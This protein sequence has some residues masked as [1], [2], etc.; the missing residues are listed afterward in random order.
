MKYYKFLTKENT[1]KYSKFDFTKWLPDEGKPGDWIPEVEK[2]E[3]CVSGY[4]ACSAND[5]L[6]WLGW[7]EFDLYEV[8]LGD[9]IRKDTN[10]IVSNKIRFIRK[11]ETWNDKTARLFACWCVKQIWHL[12]SD[13]RSKHAVTIAEQYANGEA[14]K[15]DMD[16]AWAAA[17]AGFSTAAGFSAWAAASTGYSAWAA[18]SARAAAADAAGDAAMA[19]AWDAQGEKLIEMLGLG[20]E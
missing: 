5:L 16:A 14:S 17:L 18:A 13:E 6:E 20:N 15:K 11:I 1:G 8:E 4:H 2:L 12:L 10:K 19:A 7:L 9:G 3:L